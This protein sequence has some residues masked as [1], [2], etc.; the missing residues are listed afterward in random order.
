MSA[1]GSWVILLE[2]P[3]LLPPIYSALDSVPSHYIGSEC[4]Y[5]TNPVRQV[6]LPS[7]FSGSRVR[8]REAT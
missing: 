1:T 7:T 5:R 3:P 8:C 6:L 2:S 4:D